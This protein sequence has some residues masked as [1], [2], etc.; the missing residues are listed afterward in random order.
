MNVKVA[1]RRKKKKMQMMITLIIAI[2]VAIV[3][4]VFV[5]TGSDSSSD[6]NLD[7]DNSVA[8][9]D[10]DTDDDTTS[11]EMQ[12]FVIS[13]EELSEGDLILVSSA[14]ML[15]AD[16]NPTDLGLLS[17]Y[18]NGYYILKDNT[19]SLRLHVIEALNDLMEDCY[20][21][22]LTSLGVISSYRSYEY[23]EGLFDAKVAAV[24]YDEA[25][26]WVQ[27]PGGSEHQTGLTLDVSDS[28]SGSMSFLDGS[29]DEAYFHEMA[30]YYGFILRYTEEKMDVTAISPEPWHYRYVGTMHALKIY[31]LDMAL[32]EYLEYLKDFTVDSPLELSDG[33]DTYYC[34]YVAAEDGDTTVQV[35]VGTEYYY[36]GNNYDGFIIW[37]K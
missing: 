1:R 15:T 3:V 27:I 19:Q 9:P 23:Q 10:V 31:E 14:A 25:I 28:S 32:E 21:N 20:A 11:V 17:E 4:A 26:T 36:S 33:T 6:D 8:T 13:E 12:S 16:D 29:D 24:G 22:G 37:Y 34:F 35:P 5:F 2:I 30:P 18:G 7:S